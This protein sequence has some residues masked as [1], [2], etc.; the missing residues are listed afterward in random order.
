M[1]ISLSSTLAS[2]DCLSLGPW[3]DHIKTRT[4]APSRVV[5]IRARPLTGPEDL[6]KLPRSMADAT[7]LEILRRG[8]DAWNGWR[9]AHRHLSIDLSFADLRRTNLL[10]ANLAGANLHGAIFTGVFLTRANLAGANLDGASLDR[11]NLYDANLGD[12]SLDRANLL[13]AMLNR[14]DLKGAFLICADLRCAFL[15]DADLKGAFI[16]DANLADAN[17]HG[18]NFRN[19]TLSGANLNGARCVETIWSD[20]DLST[21]IGLDS[22]VHDGPSTIDFRTLQRSGP[23]PLAFLRGCGL[24]DS[25]IDYL[26]PLLNQAIQFYS[27]FISYSTEDQQF[28]ERLHADLQNKGVRCWF[29]P[30]QMQG[31][32]KIHEQID[33]AIRVYDRLLLILSPHSMS[34]RWVK[35]EIANARKKELT[36]GLQMLFP[37]RLVDFEAIRQWKLFD[38]DIGDDSAGEIREYFIP[39]FSNWKNHDSYEHAFQRLL[40]DLKAE[41]GSQAST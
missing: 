41:T 30:H 11:A 13:G 34:S 25:L 3:A 28:A 10:N 35:T 5:L 21:A 38:A 1:G 6:D 14:A 26:P 23:M 40:S 19:A 29:A 36:Q 9:A 17:L 33:E 32:K 22:I 7:Q 18:A 27:C 16:T 15:Q 24:P 31:G 8:V 20:V 4:L 12:A 37:V 39:D 2:H